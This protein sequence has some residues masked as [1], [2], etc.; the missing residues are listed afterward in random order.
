MLEVRT[1]LHSSS[2]GIFSFPSFAALSK[3][4]ED[5]LIAINK[6]SG[7]GERCDKLR[8]DIA[9]LENNIERIA[10]VDLDDPSNEKNDIIRRKVIKT[11]QYSQ[12]LLIYSSR[13]RR[14]VR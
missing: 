11:R 9:S 8:D 5:L 1:I 12:E 13:S 7:I 3:K 2:F 4:W 10:I 6:L 14:S